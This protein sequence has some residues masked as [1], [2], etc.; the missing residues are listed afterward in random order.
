MGE[1]LRNDLGAV[2]S[3]LAL[4]EVRARFESWRATKLRRNSPIPEELWAAAIGLIGPRCCPADVSRA[5]D[6]DTSRLMAK[7]A[8][9]SKTGPGGTSVALPVPVAKADH[10][11]RESRPPRV[12]AFVEMAIHAVAP[13]A[14]PVP[15]FDPRHDPRMVIEMRLPDGTSLKVSQREP[16]DAASLV[17]DI[18]TI[19]R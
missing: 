3:P 13:P 18:L 15:V 17:L 4:D 7:L 14:A 19:R 9:R 12:P 16:I 1:E 8:D 10:G 6:L 11:S 2:T 5:L